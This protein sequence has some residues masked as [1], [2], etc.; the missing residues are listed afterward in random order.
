MDVAILLC[1][2]ATALYAPDHARRKVSTGRESRS[3]TLGVRVWLRE[4]KAMV[5]YLGS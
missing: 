1:V 4:T 5:L 3:Q 2:G